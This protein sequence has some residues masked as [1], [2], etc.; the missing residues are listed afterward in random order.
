MKFALWNVKQTLYSTKCM[1]RWIMSE[2]S[3]R[4][5]YVF[6][7]RTQNDRAGVSNPAK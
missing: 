4:R 7:G 5:R 1:S 6:I 2:V 3:H